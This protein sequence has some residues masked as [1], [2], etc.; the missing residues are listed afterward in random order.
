MLL[1]RMKTEVK[2]DPNAMILARNKILENA[3]DAGCF[4]FCLIYVYI[5]ILANM[6]GRSHNPR[7]ILKN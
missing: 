7:A 2:T 6:S 5:G 3:L 1:N 4:Y